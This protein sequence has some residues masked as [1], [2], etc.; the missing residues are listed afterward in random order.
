MCLG[1]QVID[2]ADKATDNRENCKTVVVLVLACDKALGQVP[3][4]PAGKE[5]WGKCEQQLAALKA[6]LEDVRLLV[7][8]FGQERGMLMRLIMAAEDEAAFARCHKALIDAMS[9]SHHD[10]TICDGLGG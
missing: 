7:V 4:T 6:A 1:L 2:A 8:R 3:N 5:L 9:V 10:F